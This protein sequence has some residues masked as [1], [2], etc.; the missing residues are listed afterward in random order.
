[1]TTT[2]SAG[3]QPDSPKTSTD[4]NQTQQQQYT[5]RIVSASDNLSAITATLGT[6][7]SMLDNLTPNTDFERGILTYLALLHSQVCE[8]RAKHATLREEQAK[9]RDE[10][11]VR[12]RN[13][14]E[15]VQDLTLNVVKTE[16]YSRRDT[17]TMVGL[18]KPESET[19]AQLCSKVA[20]VLSASG[21]TVTANDLSVAH[22]NS[23]HTK[24][25]RGKTVPPSVTVRFAKISKKDSVL[26]GYRNYDPTLKK[27]R[28][29]RVYQSLTPHYSSLRNFIVDFFK[30][31][32]NCENYGD[33]FNA[34]LKLKW[35]TYQSPTSGFAIKLVSGVGEYFNGIH[36]I[37]D[38]LKKIYDIF[39]SCRR[40]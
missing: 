12:N 34:G 16:Q 6:M 15:T 1:M 32:S 38:F 26:R 27:S 4:S 21:E 11:I 22:R 40:N 20:D 2:R 14:R 28:D 29:V 23:K 31:D 13:V 3:N 17:I 18:A 39:P 19:D 35:A 30:S 37:Q 8:A 24:S 25:Y 33:V 7:K 10:L 5:D 9:L 36:T